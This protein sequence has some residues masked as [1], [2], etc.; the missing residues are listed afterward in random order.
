MTLTLELPLGLDPDRVRLHTAISL[1]QDGE[2]GVGKAAQVAGISYRAFWDELTARGIPVVI[3]DDA[4]DMRLELESIRHLI[5]A[6]KE[7][8]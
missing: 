6:R 7:A 1:F 2:V 8:A 5:D 4:E 3:F